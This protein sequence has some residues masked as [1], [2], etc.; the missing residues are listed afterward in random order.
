MSTN[1]V[2]LINALSKNEAIKRLLAHDVSNPFSETLPAIDP[3]VIFNPDNPLSKIRPQPFNVG[4]VTE[5]GSFIR[6]Y[7]NRGEFDESEAIV[8]SAIVIDI[9]VAESLW[10]INDGQKSL[11]RPYEIMGRI[12]DMLGKR[13]IPTTPLRIN[14]NGWQHFAVNEKF[15]AIRLYCDYYSVEA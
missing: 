6:L 8:E 14:F 10:L 12:V 11:V 4:T 1:M 9:I 13:A 3:K 5:D 15:G 2:K 7:Y